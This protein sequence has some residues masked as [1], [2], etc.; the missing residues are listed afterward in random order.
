MNQILQSNWVEDVAGEVQ[1][2]ASS[3]QAIVFE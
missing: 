1:L 2:A 3:R